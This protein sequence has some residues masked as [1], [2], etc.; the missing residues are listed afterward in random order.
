MV[1]DVHRTIKY[2]GIFMY[3]A[4]KSSPNGKLR[5]LYECNPMSFIVTE[6][7]GMATNGKIP[8]LDIQ[9]TSIHQRAPC[10]L[11]SKKDIEELLSYLK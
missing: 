7:G 2:G 3:P 9:P 5:L 4:T 1:A 6:A 11:G 8:I 10:Y